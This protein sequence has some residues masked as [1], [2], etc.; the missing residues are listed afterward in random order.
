M[1]PFKLSSADLLNCCLRLVEYHL[2]L[3]QWHI[4]CQFIPISNTNLNMISLVCD[5][6]H[7]L[8]YMMTNIISGIL[9]G[10]QDY[11]EEDLK[12][13]SVVT[14]FDILRN[15]LFYQCS[16][17]TQCLS[18]S[19]LPVLL[20]KRLFSCVFLIPLSTTFPTKED[21]QK[22][23]WSRNVTSLTFQRT[24]LCNWMHFSNLS[25]RHR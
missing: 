15:I 17:I 9:W 19:R 13:T 14:L 3:R 7:L 4:L 12:C 25:H 20:T 22:R 2:L 16:V 5:F 8:L 10:S 1:A 23:V 24:A 21:Y 11:R 18:V 6:R